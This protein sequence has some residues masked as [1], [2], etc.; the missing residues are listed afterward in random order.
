MAALR[1]G[2]VDPDGWRAG[3]GVRWRRGV[4]SASRSHD[5]LH[6]DG[7]RYRDLGG[8]PRSE[9]AVDDARHRW[10]E[11]EYRDPAV[12][13]LRRARGPDAAGQH[14]LDAALLR[15]WPGLH[16]SSLVAANGWS[17]PLVRDHATGSAVGPRRHGHERRHGRE[18]TSAA[19]LRRHELGDRSIHSYTRRLLPRGRDRASAGLPGVDDGDLVAAWTR[20]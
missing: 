4:R 6:N 16:P 3:A 8:V 20:A 9:S 14:H 1:A 19:V 7:R 10:T 18:A 17:A 12:P 11:C 13:L 5:P 2:V 15:A